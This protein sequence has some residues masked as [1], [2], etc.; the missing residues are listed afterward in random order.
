MEVNQSAST[1]Q[2]LLN[3][4]CRNMCAWTNKAY[5]YRSWETSAKKTTTITIAATVTLNMYADNE[6]LFR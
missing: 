5:G 1:M 6:V 3:N 4:L 2:S